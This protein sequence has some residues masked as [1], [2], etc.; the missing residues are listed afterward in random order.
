[1]CFPRRPEVWN[2]AEI[3]KNLK[4]VIEKLQE[5]KKELNNL[6]QDIDKI[7]AFLVMDD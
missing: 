2:D 7:K 3:H 5:V 4:K 6:R 1:M